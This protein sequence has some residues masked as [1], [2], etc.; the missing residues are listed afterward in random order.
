MIAKKDP[1]TAAKARCSLQPAAAMCVG[2]FKSWSRYGTLDFCGVRAVAVFRAK[3]PQQASPGQRPIGA[4]LVGWAFM[5][6]G[7]KGQRPLAGGNA[8]GI[9]SGAESAT[10]LAAETVRFPARP[11]G[12]IPF[13]TA[14]RGRCPR[15]VAVGRSGR[16]ARMPNAKL[17]LMGQRP[18]IHPP[19]IKALKG[20]GKVCRPFRALIVLPTTPRA[21]LVPRLPWAGLCRAFGPEM[22]Q[23]FPV[24]YRL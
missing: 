9:G 10:K 7:P 13:R 21:A 5:Q 17:A 23:P 1:R 3:G 12:R 15:L 14:I 19:R 16:T 4:N 2:C 18:G 11:P 8:P 20:R 24:P 6:N 22:P